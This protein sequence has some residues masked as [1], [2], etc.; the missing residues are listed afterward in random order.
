MG[1]LEFG[2]YLGHPPRRIEIRVIRN[3]FNLICYFKNELL[4]KYVLLILMN[5]ISCYICRE[6]ES[7]QK[8]DI[9]NLELEEISE[10]FLQRGEKK[11]RAK[12]VY[13]WL[14][15]KGVTH[16]EE[17]T[18]LSK[19][20]RTVLARNFS[21]HPV[22]IN[23]V[24]LSKDGTIKSGFLLYDDNVVEGVL[25]PTKARATACISSQVGCSLACSF[26]ATGKLKFRRNLEIGEI[27]DQVT[28]IRK[29]ANEQLNRQLTNIVLM[30]MGEPL[31]NYANV[32][33]AMNRV[34]SLEGLGMSPQR[35]TLSTA[36]ISKM[37][38]KLGDEKVKYNLAL[39]LHA[40]NDKKRE[41][42]IPGNRTNSLDSLSKA[43]DYYYSKTK[44]RVTFEYLLLRDFND[45]LQD[46]KE[47]AE[48]CKVVPCKINLIEY[49][50]AGNDLFHPSTTEKTND[51]AEFLKG[52]N[53]IVNI[54][55]SR[56]K[57]IDAACGQLA[58]Q[59]LIW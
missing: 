21:I 48:F 54:R 25:I 27:F 46:A 4:D 22:R 36:G 39:S 24:Q 3:L 17:M 11:F 57:D 6:M 40:T 14:W 7:H 1:Y 2:Y 53:L 9:R 50:P 26:C 55:K 34:S 35:I 49:N 32:L 12:Q 43:L 56:G 52:K 33:K 58:G 18:N 10:F 45:T 15:A 5:H 47:L 59:K 13:E 41:K 16:F 19:P 37:I 8:P 42:I 38:E 30:G 51:F 44:N 23:N 29:Q 31:L 20:L 28:I